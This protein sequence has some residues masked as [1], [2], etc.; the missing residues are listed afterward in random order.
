MGLVRTPAEVSGKVLETHFLDVLT[1]NIHLTQESIE[2]R[3][4][5]LVT[6]SP[7]AARPTSFSLTTILGQRVNSSTRN[8]NR[9]EPVSNLTHNDAPVGPSLSLSSNSGEFRFPVR[10]DLI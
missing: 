5:P 4:R 10:P 1:C 6:P 9:D 2:G 8:S 3:V 7:S